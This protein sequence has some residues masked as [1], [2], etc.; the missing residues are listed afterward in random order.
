MTESTGGLD[1]LTLGFMVA[2]GV[3]ALHAQGQSLLRAAHPDLFQTEQL[4]QPGL[5]QGEP[6]HE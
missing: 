2:E 6:E 4:P 3:D 5:G 1:D